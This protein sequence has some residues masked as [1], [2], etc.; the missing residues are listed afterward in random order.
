M[1]PNKI[2]EQEETVIAPGGCGRKMP[3]RELLNGLTASKISSIS[4][5][6]FIVN[7]SPSVGFTIDSIF[8]LAEHWGEFARM[9][10]VHTISD[11]N[12]R[13][14]VA[15]HVSVSV[16]IPSSAEARLVELLD[17][18]ADQC[19]ASDLVFAKGHTVIGPLG[20][21][22]SAIGPQQ[23]PIPQIGGCEPLVVLLTK[24]LGAARG[25]RLSCLADDEPRRQSALQAMLRHHQQCA[26]FLGSFTTDVSGFGLEAALES[27]ARKSN[28]R[29]LCNLR[30]LTRMDGCYYE[31]PT[32][33]EYALNTTRVENFRLS[34]PGSSPAAILSLFG[35]ELCGPLATLVM[36]SQVESVLEKLSAFEF[37]PVVIGEA[38]AGRTDGGKELIYE[39]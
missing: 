17:G 9:A 1:G 30:A 2:P 34:H 3:E 25:Y 26:A 37:Q 29:I 8:P 38:V 36:R 7:G 10:V 24:P 11:L 22:V 27:L 35:V 5:D 6:C 31:I 20:M 19:A 21:T 15:T 33:C 4:D 16:S 14:C 32:S 13:Q 39:D 28:R 12:A 18:V 23:A